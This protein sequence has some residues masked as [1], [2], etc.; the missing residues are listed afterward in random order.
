MRV[1]VR[2]LML[3][4]V[5]VPLLAYDFK[6]CEKRAELSMQRIGNTYGIAVQSTQYSKP[7][8]FVYSPY[9]T[10]IGY[11]I[12]KHD[13]FLGM[14]LLETRRTLEPVEIKAIHSEM[15]EDEIAS[16]NPQ[17]SVSG[18]I[19]RRMQSPIDYAKLN[20]PTFKNSL[21]STVCDS[22]YGIGIG[23]N[24]FIEKEY[25]ERF[26]NSASVY[27]GDIG[28]RVIQNADN[29]VE[30]NMVDPFF[31]N[32]PFK[33]GDVIR[34]VN[35]AMTPNIPSF[36]HI[37]FDLKE[38]SV[39]P[40]EIMRNGAVMEVSVRVDKL[41]G[42]M[43]LKDDFLS[44]VH[45]DIDDN[46]MITRVGEGAQNGFERLKVGDKVLRVN[47]RDV[48]QGYEAII[49]LL[50]EYPDMHQRWLIARNNFQF[51]IDV[52]DN[53]A[54]FSAESFNEGLLNEDTRFS[55]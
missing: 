27:Y 2:T 14:Y 22:V 54:K 52:N 49:R 42:G 17:N 18:K 5:C 10:P 33:F 20:T 35:G 46:F 44:R 4:S 29:A 50:G 28:V 39:V 30:V 55:F 3:L 21:M 53:K 19:V 7:V 36:R 16:V 45:I 8:L 32:N 9:A 31:K 13:P 12:L 11:R 23:K 26:L 43:L 15:L 48:P 24:S 37:V 47:Q 40:V 1:L 41:R 34:S 6:A 38:G 25:L 51:F